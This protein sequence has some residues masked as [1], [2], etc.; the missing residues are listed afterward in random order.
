MIYFSIT[1]L[2]T[3]GYGDIVA[4]TNVEKIFAIFMMLAGI[5][6]FSFIMGSFIEILQTFNSNRSGTEDR[7]YELNNWMKQL[8]RFRQHR[9]LPDNLTKQIH[10]HFKYYWSNNRINQVQKNNDFTS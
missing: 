9:P 6:F 2:S 8:I 10:T 5:G 3:V 7:T 4:Q 1:S